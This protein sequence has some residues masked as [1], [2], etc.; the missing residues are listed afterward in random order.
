MRARARAHHLRSHHLHHHT[1]ARQRLP[2]PPNQK[3]QSRSAG[4]AIA[5]PLSCWMPAQP[6]R[7]SWGWLDAI[8]ASIRGPHHSLARCGRRAFFAQQHGVSACL[9]PVLSR[10]LTI[11][12][13]RSSSSKPKQAYLSSICQSPAARAGTKTRDGTGRDRTGRRSHELGDGA[14]DDKP[15]TPAS[16]IAVLRVGVDSTQARGDDRRLTCHSPIV[17]MERAGKAPS[18]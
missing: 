5:D 12:L 18:T 9:Q 17:L 7:P 13:T 2:K 1:K 14:G 6:G 3:M 15:C 8:S 10:R 11:R 4:S 16:F